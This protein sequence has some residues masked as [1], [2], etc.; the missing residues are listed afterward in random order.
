[1]AYIVRTALGGIVD[2]ASFTPV[3]PTHASGDLIL[4]CVTNT[5]FGTAISPATSG[6]SMIGTQA[7]S[8]TTRQAWAYK[9]A[10][11]S[12]EKKDRLD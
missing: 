5:N 9:I 1:M 8:A 7:A 6:W 12:S 3:I 10:A 2:A 11:S 4:C